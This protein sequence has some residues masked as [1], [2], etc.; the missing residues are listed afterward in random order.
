MKT[1]LVLQKLV[2]MVGHAFLISNRIRIALVKKALMET[3]V[4]SMTI[5]QTKPIVILRQTFVLIVQT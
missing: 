3:A 5:I 1:I 2:S 4:K